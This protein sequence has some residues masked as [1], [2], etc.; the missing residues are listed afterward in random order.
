MPRDKSA[1]HP[2]NSQYQ[3][4]SALS[5]FPKRRISIFSRVEISTSTIFIIQ[6]TLSIFP[7]FTITAFEKQITLERKIARSR[8]REIGKTEIKKKDTVT[9]RTSS[10]SLRATSTSFSF[11]LFS[12]PLFLHSCFASAPLFHSLFLCPIYSGRR[13]PVTRRS[14]F[15][16]RH[17]S[18]G[19]NSIC[20]SS[21]GNEEPSL[22]TRDS[23]DNAK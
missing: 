18:Y 19:R 11:S 1:K 2:H 22:E 20:L 6:H 8:T 4:K 7:V 9:Q 21:R 23:I 14:V 3:Q 12:F 13:E 5:A 15:F 16:N 17:S 10:N